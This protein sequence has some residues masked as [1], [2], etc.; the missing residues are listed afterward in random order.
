[1]MAIAV[2]LIVIAIVVAATA[3]R[4]HARRHEPDT[5]PAPARLDTFVTE[6]TQRRTRRQPPSARGVA[7][8]CDDIARRVRSGSSL[9]DA[10]T[11]APCDAAVGRAITPLVLGLDRGQSLTDAVDRVDTA[12]PHLHLALGVLAAASRI[13]GPSAA[14]ID[15]AAVLLRQR[16]ADLEERSTHAAQARLSTHVMT[17]VPLVML[18]VL[19]VTDADVRSA[20]TSPTGA[21][22]IVAGLALNAAGW[23]WMHRI[24]RT[25]T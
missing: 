19:V 20:A 15:R 13:G 18:A 5:A 25:S 12:R 6:W 3:V 17:A 11:G 14:S 7:A 21:T 24:V 9:R 8:W 22:C 16:A 4:P 10:V 2:T 23:L 1:M